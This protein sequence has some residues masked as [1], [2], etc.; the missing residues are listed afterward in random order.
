MET[1]LFAMYSFTGPKGVALFATEADAAEAAQTASAS[2]PG[3]VFAWFKAIP[4][5][6]MKGVTQPAQ[7]TVEP[8]TS[9]AELVQ[10]FPQP[11]PVEETP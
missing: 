8:V 9:L 7:V 3:H 1:E 10:Y 11:T 2:M 5:G 4:L 6:A